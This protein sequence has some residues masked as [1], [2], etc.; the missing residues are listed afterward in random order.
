MR[1]ERLNRVLKGHCA[2]TDSQN[3][4]APFTLENVV[5]VRDLHFHSTAIRPEP[6][7]RNMSGNIRDKCASSFV[8]TSQPLLAVPRHDPQDFAAVQT[9]PQ[10]FDVGP[11]QTKASSRFKQAIDGKVIAFH[12]GH[13]RLTSANCRSGL[14]Q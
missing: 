2:A 11:F 12:S 5:A 14:I 1:S 7:N 8:L 6:K 4:N 10:M 13:P 3:A 9:M